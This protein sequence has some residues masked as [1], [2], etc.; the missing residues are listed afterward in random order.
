MEA[1][2]LSVRGKLEG[3]NTS[4]PYNPLV[5]IPVAH[6]EVPHLLGDGWAIIRH[7]LAGVGSFSFSSPPFQDQKSSVTDSKMNHQ[8]VIPQD[9]ASQTLIITT[10]AKSRTGLEPQGST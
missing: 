7:I 8:S 3:K 10:K 4:T 2:W 9:M 5:S 1:G 6:V